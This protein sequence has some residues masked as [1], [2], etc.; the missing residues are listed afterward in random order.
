MPPAYIRQIIAK[1]LGTKLVYTE[2]LE[3]IER[4]PDSTLARM[5]LGY[6]DAAGKGALKEKVFDGNIDVFRAVQRF[7]ENGDGAQLVEALLEEAR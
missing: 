4:C 3:Y 6:V 1:R 2:G 5:A 7:E